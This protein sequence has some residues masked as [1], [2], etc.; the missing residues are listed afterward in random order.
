MNDQFTSRVSLHPLCL[1]FM[2]NLQVRLLAEHHGIHA[3]N[4]GTVIAQ[5][6]CSYLVAMDDGR[7]LH[8][9]DDEVIPLPEDE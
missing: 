6:P 4:T 9:W 8:V 7:E 1:H 2:S 3:L 5:M